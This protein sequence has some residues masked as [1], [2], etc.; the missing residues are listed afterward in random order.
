MLLYALHQPDTF[1]RGGRPGTDR[2]SG[3]GGG[4]LAPKE[5]RQRPEFISPHNEVY[6]RPRSRI[7][8]ARSRPG[9]MPGG[10]CR[11][12]G[13]LTGPLGLA[14]SRGSAARTSGRSCRGREAQPAPPPLAEERPLPVFGRGW[15]AGAGKGR[16][17]RRPE[18]AGAKGEG[19]GR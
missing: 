1:P 16:S 13:D 12:W 18:P 9:V 19:R 11:W 2:G 5:Q 8:A 7:E 15:A 17:G 10:R 6:R 4:A 14:P 3:E